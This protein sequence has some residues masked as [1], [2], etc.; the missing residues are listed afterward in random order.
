MATDEKAEIAP[1]SQPGGARSVGLVEP[2]TWTFDDPL[3][4]DCGRS[5]SPVTQAYE[6]YGELN[7]QRD[8]AILIFHALSGDAHVTG[9]HA[10]DDP[11]PGWWDCLVGPGKP[12]DTSKYFIVCANV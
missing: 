10:P 11:K 4:L 9:Y 3:A 5:L 8:N 12:F 1:D 7:P 6:T 2:K